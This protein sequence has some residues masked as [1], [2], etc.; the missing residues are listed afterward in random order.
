M[1]SSSPGWIL[2]PQKTLKPEW[3]SPSRRP[4]S[5][6]PVHKHVDQILSDFAFG[7]ESYVV[8]VVDKRETCRV[9][10]VLSETR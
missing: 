10:S 3:R 6:R 7:T 4:T 5:R 2:G 8:Y 9:W 1:A